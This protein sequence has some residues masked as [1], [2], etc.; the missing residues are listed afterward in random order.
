MFFVAVLGGVPVILSNTLSSMLRSIGLSGK[1]SF[2]VTAGF[3]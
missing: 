3:P 1:A 2:G